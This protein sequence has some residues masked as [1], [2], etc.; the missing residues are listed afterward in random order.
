MRSHGVCGLAY[1]NLVRHGDGFRV[2]VHVARRRGPHLHGVR[3]GLGGLGQ[4]HLARGLVHGEPL[5]GVVARI[6]VGHGTHGVRDRHVGGRRGGGARVVRRGEARLRGLRSHRV[7][8]LRD[9]KR[10]LKRARVAVLARHGDGCCTDINVVLVGDIVAR[11]GHELIARRD[12]DGWPLGGAVPGVE[13]LVQRERGYPHGLF[14]GARAG[15][16][17]LVRGAVARDCA[18]ARHGR[19]C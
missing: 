14:R 4:R 16:G 18:G 8:S 7:R 6:G 11:R 10:H 19:G 1:D 9:C 2:V 12:D 5:G 13:R 15:R 3:P 17:R